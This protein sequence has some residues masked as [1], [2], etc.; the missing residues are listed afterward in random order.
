MKPRSAFIAGCFILAGIGV[1]MAA[2]FGW[3]VASR[4]PSTDFAEPLRQRE[5]NFFVFS[6]FASALALDVTGFLV[7]IALVG[8]TILTA[9]KNLIRSP[10]ARNR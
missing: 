8:F 7:G 10:S 6:G 2:F 9:K 3:Q 4:F 1:L 5:T